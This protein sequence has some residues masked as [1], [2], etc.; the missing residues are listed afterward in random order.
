MTDTVRAVVEAA[1][2]RADGH[3]GTG[4][5]TVQQG[6]NRLSGIGVVAIHDDDEVRVAR[7]I[8]P[9]DDGKPLPSPALAQHGRS[10]GA[11]IGGRVVGG[12]V[13]HDDDE[14]IGQHAAEVRDDL[15]DA[16]RLVPARDDDGDGLISSPPQVRDRLSG[17]GRGR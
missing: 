13:V 10:R 7:G 2:P 14:R 12:R 16:S 1:Q 6:V 8:E 3:V 15:R 4:A 5:K 11:R 9:S 17:V